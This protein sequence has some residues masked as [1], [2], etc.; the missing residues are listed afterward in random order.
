MPSAK[1][2]AAVAVRSAWVRCASGQG[3]GPERCC[4]GPPLLVLLID[5]EENASRTGVLETAVESRE[6]F[7]RAGTQ[8][9]Q[10]PW[11]PIK[12]SLG[13]ATCTTV[14]PLFAC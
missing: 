6:R 9:E 7:Q 2:A 5:G 11:P 10:F 8:L 1:R 12:L 4:A 13:P 3:E 14:N